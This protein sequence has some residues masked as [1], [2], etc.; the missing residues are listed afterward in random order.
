MLAQV[1]QMFGLRQR[2]AAEANPQVKTLL[3]RQIDTKRTPVRPDQRAGLSV[4]WVDGR[5]DRDCRRKLG[6]TNDEVRTVSSE[7]PSSFLISDS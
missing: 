5:G 7:S 4:V 6:A 3:Q 1:E 2:L